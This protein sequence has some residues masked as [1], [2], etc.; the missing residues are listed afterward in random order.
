MSWFVGHTWKNNISGIPD[1]LNYCVIFIV[2]IQVT[3]VTMD[4]GLE[5]H[6]VNKTINVQVCKPG[7]CTLGVLCINI[8]KKCEKEIFI[9]IGPRNVAICCIEKLL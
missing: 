5:T 9:R 2:Y 4:R 1:C 7:F 8:H 6:D 3:N